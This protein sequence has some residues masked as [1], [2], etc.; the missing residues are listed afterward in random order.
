MCSVID[1]VNY[2]VTSVPDVP[3]I[4]WVCLIKGVI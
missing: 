2:Q 3:A 4:D 1:D